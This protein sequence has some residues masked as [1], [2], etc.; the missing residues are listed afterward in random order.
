MFDGDNEEPLFCVDT[1]ELLARGDFAKFPPLDSRSLTCSR[2][3][4]E[5]NLLKPL[6][7]VLIEGTVS[8]NEVLDLASVSEGEGVNFE[9]SEVN[10][11]PPTFCK[12]VHQPKPRKSREQRIVRVGRKGSSRSVRRWLG[13]VEMKNVSKKVKAQAPLIRNTE[14][15]TGHL[16]ILNKSE[17]GEPMVLRILGPDDKLE[18]KKVLKPG[19][20][21]LVDGELATAMATPSKMLSQKYDYE[22]QATRPEAVLQYSTTPR[23]RDRQASMM[24]LLQSRPGDHPGEIPPAECGRNSIENGTKRD[25]GGKGRKLLARKEFKEDKRE[26]RFEFM[27][28]LLS[29]TMQAHHGEDSVD[30]LYTTVVDVGLSK[31]STQAHHHA[32]DLWEA[33][34]STQVDD[35]ERIVERVNMEDVAKEGAALKLSKSQGKGAGGDQVGLRE[36]RGDSCALPRPKSGSGV[37]GRQGSWEWEKL[38]KDIHAGEAVGAKEEGGRCGKRWRAQ[39]CSTPMCFKPIKHNDLGGVTRLCK[40]C[41]DVQVMGFNQFQKEGVGKVMKGH[42]QKEKNPVVKSRLEGGVG[43]EVKPVVMAPPSSGVKRINRVRGRRES[44][45]IA[46]RTL[47]SVNRSLTSTSA[48]AHMGASRVVL[49]NQK[50]VSPALTWRE[51]RRKCKEAGLLQKGRKAELLARL[52]WREEDAK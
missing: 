45:K 20:K 11:P 16:V 30:E 51:L 5:N 4:D 52:G 46:M 43:G 48:R 15:K 18:E 24:Q 34:P 19:M 13:S 49:K 33:M 26:N 7:K 10:P 2:L 41:I 14:G 36:A 38:Q 32:E 44:A 22:K 17:S 23:A 29:S 39:R 28:P 9:T 8:A 21:L 50:Q 1:E 37:W 3:V 27:E 42:N 25:V 12:A 40:D 35:G 31:G 6:P 47:S